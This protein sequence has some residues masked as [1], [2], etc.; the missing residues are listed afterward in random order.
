MKLRN[1]LG[2]SCV[3]LLTLT[4][5]AIKASASGISDGF[6]LSTTEPGAFVDLS[7]NGLGM[8]ELVGVPLEHPDDLGTT[9]TIIHRTNSSSI[10]E[11]GVGFA[12]IEVVV[13]HLRSKYPVDLSLL[14]PPGGIF[15]GEMADLHTII[16]KGG[17]IPGLPDTTDS[18]LMNHPSIGRMRIR[19]EN[20]DPDAGTFDACY[21]EPNEVD[22]PTCDMELGVAGGGVFA[23]AI[24]TVVGGDPSKPVDILLML[25]HPTPKIAL[26]TT[27]AMWS[28]VPKP[29]GIPQ[30][31]PAGQF[32]VEDFGMHT[33]PHP[34][35]PSPVELRSFTIE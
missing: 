11:G 13:L 3:F 18:V 26:S 6:D 5:S 23:H 27:N 14:F 31:F 12:D 19:H 1:N 4:L 20:P 32:F 22:H 25:P 10:N 2:L 16:N 17:L 29:G 30:A 33:G 8:I 9:D 34:V 15:H 28:H 24:F 35:E 21:G 7:G